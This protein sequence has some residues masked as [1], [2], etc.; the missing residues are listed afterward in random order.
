LTI[1]GS[2]VS[3]YSGVVYPGDVLTLVVTITPTTS[4]I[5]TFYDNTNHQIGTVSTDLTGIARLD[6]T[7]PALT[8]PPNND[9]YIY[10]ATIP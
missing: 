8:S 10:T 5:V 9:Y 6:W 2:S 4:K 3:P 1:N 7:I